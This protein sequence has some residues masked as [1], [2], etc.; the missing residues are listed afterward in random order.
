[1]LVVIY[2]DVQKEYNKN[3]FKKASINRSKKRKWGGGQAEV[4]GWDGLH[5]GR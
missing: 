3:V 1:M 4:G 5:R 2:V